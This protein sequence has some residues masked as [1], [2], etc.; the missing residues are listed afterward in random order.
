MGQATQITR[1]TP[2]DAPTTALNKSWQAALASVNA[3]SPWQYYDLVG[4]QWPT[5]TS[6]D[7]NKASATNPAGNPAPQFLANTTLESYTQGNTPSTS[8]SCIECHKNAAATTGK[9]SDFTYMLSMAKSA[10]P[11][12]TAPA[13]TPKP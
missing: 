4:T 10:T 13:T 1:V 11:A 12:T 5:L 7:C 3:N 6:T 2:I 9:F 8:S